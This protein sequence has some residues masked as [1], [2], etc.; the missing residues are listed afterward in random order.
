MC[1]NGIEGSRGRKRPC[2]TCRERGKNMELLRNF[3]IRDIIVTD[4]FRDTTPGSRKMERAERR[5]QQT[6]G[7]PVNIVI[8][9]E[10]VLI[11]GYITYLLAVQHGIEQMDVYRGYMELVEALHYTGSEKAYMWRVPLWLY[12]MIETGDYII[13][14]TARGVKRVKVSRIVRQQYPEQT[15]RIKKVIKRCSR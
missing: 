5:Y 12:G 14:Q 3:A 15:R 13:V 6:G 8:N 2:Y 1:L 7:L 11:D 9:D 10:N 4:D